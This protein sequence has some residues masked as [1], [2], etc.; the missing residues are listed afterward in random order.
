MRVRKYLLVSLFIA[1][2]VVV[3]ALLA[4]LSG[5][6]TINKGVS[7]YDIARKGLPVSLPWL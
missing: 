4:V 6:A 1:T 5:I 3:I 7:P 2:V